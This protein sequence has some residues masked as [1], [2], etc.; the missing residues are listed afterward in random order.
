MNYMNLNVIMQMNRISKLKRISL[1]VSK[2]LYQK[3]HRIASLKPTDRP[4]VSS[5]CTQVDTIIHCFGI[6]SITCTL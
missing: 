5:I 6:S 1:T 4:I 3:I 2:F